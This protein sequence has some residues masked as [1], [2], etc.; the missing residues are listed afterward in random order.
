EQDDDDAG[1]EE[2]AAADEQHPLQV[3]VGAPPDPRHG[4]GQAVLPLRRPVGG[5]RRC[6]EDGCHG[7]L[8][9]RGHVVVALSARTSS[10]IFPIPNAAPPAMSTPSTSRPAERPL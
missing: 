1:G 6:V 10:G 7:E 8:L 2:D 9:S 4:G 5:D 3:D